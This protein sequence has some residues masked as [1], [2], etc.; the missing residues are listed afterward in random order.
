MSTALEVAHDT[1][2]SYAAPVSPALHLAY[3]QPL[4]DGDQQL[5]DFQLSVDPPP[6]E[7]AIEADVFGN[8]LCRFAV[9]APHRELHVQAVSRVRVAPRFEGLDAAAAPAWEAL[10]MRLRYV[11]RAAYEPV[12]EFVQPSPFVPRLEVLRAYA[13]ASFRPVSRGDPPAPTPPRT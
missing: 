4:A 8:P 3:L 13:H 2:Y 6:D 12:V 7:L 5:L 11:A 1:R 10:A 9:V